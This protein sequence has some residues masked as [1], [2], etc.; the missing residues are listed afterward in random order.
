[1]QGNQLRHDL[2]AVIGGGSNWSLP[3]FWAPLLRYFTGPILAIILSLAYPSFETLYD[4]PLHIMGFIVG[5]FLLVWCVVG[6]IMPSWFDIFVIEE[7]RDDWK[8]PLA[9]NV[10][11]DAHEGELA[12][13]MEAGSASSSLEKNTPAT[14]QAKPGETG[15]PDGVIRHDSDSSTTVDPRSDNPVK[16]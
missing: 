1:M 5:H 13:N 11:R 10:L 2:N 16:Y 3:S 6:F 4:D 9:P 15:G 7:R 14:K 8:Q 12:D